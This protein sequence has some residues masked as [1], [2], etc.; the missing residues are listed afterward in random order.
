[1]TSR[2]RNALKSLGLRT[3]LLL[4]LAYWGMVLVLAWKHRERA[5]R[6]ATDVDEYV[7][8]ILGGS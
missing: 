3:L 1:M 4:G 6:D 8:I 7:S 2:S 5:P